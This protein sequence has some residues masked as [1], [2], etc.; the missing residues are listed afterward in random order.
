MHVTL[1]HQDQKQNFL[2]SIIRDVES[3]VSSN[4]VQF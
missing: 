3:V 1:Q 4:L 2:V